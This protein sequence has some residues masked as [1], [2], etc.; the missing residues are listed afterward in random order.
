MFEYFIHVVINLLTVVFCWSNQSLVVDWMRPLKLA[1]IWTMAV[2]VAYL[3]NS[4]SS[5]VHLDLNVVFNFKRRTTVYA[6]CSPLGYCY[7]PPIQPVLTEKKACLNQS[8]Y[9][10]NILVVTTFLCNPAVK[11]MT[12]RFFL[13]LYWASKPLKLSNKIKNVFNS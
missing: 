8:L 7:T 6:A 9:T 4:W 12:T 3:W 1:L 5:N 11:Q 13:Y 10:F 2:Y